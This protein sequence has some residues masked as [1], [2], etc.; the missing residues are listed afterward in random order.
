[1][2]NLRS[3]RIG[4]IMK[5][6]IRKDYPILDIGEREGHTDYLDFIKL[7]ELKYPVMKGCDRHGR[8]F[9]VIKIIISNKVYAQT[10][11]QR[12][13]DD[14]NLWM[15]CMVWGAPCFLTTLGGM[16]LYQAKL[17]QLIL[18]GLICVIMPEH[19]PVF[20]KYKEIKG[21]YAILGGEKKLNAIKLI[22]RNWDICRYNPDYKMCKTIFEKG[23]KQYSKIEI[24]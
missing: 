1:M 21:Q 19:R 24:M 3:C 7:K 14:G 23:I 6:I 12:Y 13:Y 8:E 4:N 16:Q 11:F 15:G 22:Q 2:E 5:E 9:I 17:L 10:F 20:S 18:K